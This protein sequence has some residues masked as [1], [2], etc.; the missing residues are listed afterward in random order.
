MEYKVSVLVAAY[1]AER[2]LH[3]CLDSLVNQTLREIQ[4]ICVDDAS[5][6]KT[7]SILNEYAAKD[8]RI[9]VLQ[10][11]TNQGFAKSR[12]W[13][14]S[15]ATGEFVT[16][17]DSDDWLSQDA[18]EAAYTIAEVYPRA[19]SIL[20]DVQL[21]YEDSKELKPFNYRAEKRVYSG[22]EA[23]VL[24]LDFKIHGI[25][26]TRNSIHRQYP[27]DDSSRMYSDENATR[28]HFLH[29]REVHFSP[30][31]YYYR[32]HAAS[33][34]HTPSI[35]RFDYLDASLSLK[36]TLQ[37]E[38]VD[39]DI[40]ALQEYFRWTNI[41]G[42][43]IYYLQ[44]KSYFAPEERKRILRRFKEHIPLVDTALLENR[45][46]RRFG[47]IPFKK[48]FRLFRAQVWVYHTGRRVFYKVAGRGYPLSLFE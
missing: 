18:L 26:L 10:Q 32:Q 25:Y 17:V 7:L 48:C 45:V 6:D 30:G 37:E 14:L 24:A 5:T 40:I 29:S 39:K 28:I 13:A 1:N 15:M 2:F 34:T 21:Y 4:I 22:T 23:L 19:D 20:L 36:R 44:H 11:T 12:N 9:V 47:F 38:G 46:K 31:I 41:V 27:Y 16:M 35:H 43:Y 3:Q 33:A 8:D 42:L